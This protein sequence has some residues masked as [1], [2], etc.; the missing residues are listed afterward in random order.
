MRKAEIIA[1]IWMAK[2]DP[3]NEDTLLEYIG[4]FDFLVKQVEALLESDND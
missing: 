2:H 3:P 4:Q 1:A